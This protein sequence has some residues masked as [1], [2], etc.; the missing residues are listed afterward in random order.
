VA[1]TK[2]KIIGGRFACQR[3]LSGMV[4]P[5]G[6]R[7]F[8][9][10]SVAECQERAFLAAGLSLEA[11]PDPGQA[12]MLVRDDVVITRDAVKA[13]AAVA[14][15]GDVFWY[16]AGRAGDFHRTVAL[17]DEGPWLVRLAAGGEATPA[18]IAAAK[19]MEMD[20][21]ERMLTYP[22]SE[23]H[24]GISA[25]ELPICDKLVLPTRHWVQLI[26]ANLLGLGP[27]LWRGLV[28][29]SFIEA[30]A[31]IGWAATKAKSIHPLR[32]GAKLGRK[33]AGCTIHPSAVVEGCW[34]GEGVNI[35]AGAVVRGTVLSAGA[36]VEDLALVEF[37]VLAPGA[38][39]QRQAMVKYSVL[40]VASAVGGLMQLG[41]LDRNAVLKRTGVLMDMSFG[42]GV[43]IDVDGQRKGAPLGMVGVC[44]GEGSIV[45]AG[46]QIAAGRCLPPGLTV[47]A[48]GASTVVRVPADATGTMVVA[49]GGLERL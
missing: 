30:G 5:A 49:N 20:L 24:H 32:I 40:G 45:G 21:G 18:R 3:E 13:F 43:Q 17:G 34:L 36:T 19:P 29:S 14:V 22:L 7:P 1:I 26:W 33:G 38:R 2:A 47:V 8:L 39:V 41:V 46:V 6:V 31:R 11:E 10:L 35:G 28:G 23:A 27:F 16:P 12:R 44:L 42:Q 15:D 37:S 9:N 25:V 48:G 4:G